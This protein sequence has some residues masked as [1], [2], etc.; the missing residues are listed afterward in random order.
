MKEIYARGA[1]VG[2]KFGPTPA[3]TGRPAFLCAGHFFGMGGGQD[4]PY[5]EL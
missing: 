4:S 2:Q 3:E 1:G 5:M